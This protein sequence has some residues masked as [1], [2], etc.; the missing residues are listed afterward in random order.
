[1][2]TYRPRGFTL[3]ELL[4]V[5]TIIGMLMALLVP[6]V[7]A[8]RAAARKAECANNLR[9]VGQALQ[10]FASRRQGELPGRINQI[11]IR[12]SDS[13]SVVSWVAMLL[14]DLQRNDVWD[15]LR[16]GSITANSSADLIPRLAPILCPV[17]VQ[18]SGTVPGLSYV[19]NS[20]YWDVP[21][22]GNPWGDYP[23]NGAFHRRIGAGAAMAMN[24]DQ[25]QDG[26]AN[27][28][29]FSENTQAG[30]PDSPTGSADEPR[31]WLL[32]PTELGDGF[33]WVNDPNPSPQLQAR[34]NQ[35]REVLLSSSAYEGPQFCRPSSNHPDGV[36]AAY[37]DG[38]VQYLRD[39]VAYHVY[40]QLMTPYG[41]RAKIPPNGTDANIELRKYVLD[42]S[43]Y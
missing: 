37:F 28:L 43:D 31:S 42:A 9:Q 39:N 34:I 40:Q 38:H 25:V 1:M 15:A 2:K 10:A 22:D 3:V 4:V 7:G 30:P 11:A 35:G 29:L 17:D 6:A 19:G 32:S 36:N 20:G 12:T 16:D 23:A 5:I 24:L 8:A 14:P 13:P 33:V 18:A 21:T 26:V 27:T 41:R